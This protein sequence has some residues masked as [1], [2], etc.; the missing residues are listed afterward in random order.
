MKS[1]IE[2]T[3]L[4]RMRIREN[5]PLQMVGSPPHFR[6]GRTGKQGRPYTRRTQG[7]KTNIK[8]LSYHNADLTAYLA[9]F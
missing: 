7:R 5:F 9:E 4:T 8:H 3:I 2:K 6:A 1:G